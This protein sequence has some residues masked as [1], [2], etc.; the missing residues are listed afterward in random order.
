MHL[1]PQIFSFH[2][3]WR[4][5]EGCRGVA[6]DGSACLVQARRFWQTKGKQIAVVLGGV[7][8]GSAALQGTLGY[9]S[10]NITKQWFKQIQLRAP[11]Q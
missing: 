10:E 4:A 11:L 1:P 9:R 8:W 6:A 5:I 2:L 3:L 7:V